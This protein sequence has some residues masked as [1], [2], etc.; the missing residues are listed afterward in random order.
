MAR[1]REPSRTPPAPVNLAVTRTIDLAPEDWAWATWRPRPAQLPAPP[2]V[3][4]LPFKLRPAANR[5]ARLLVGT[6]S[7]EWLWGTFTFRPPIA[8][9][10]AHFWLSAVTAPTEGTTPE[11]LAR[12]LEKETF[13]GHIT[14][15]AVAARVADGG[16]WWADRRLV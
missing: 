15:G 4:A 16:T 3:K 10:A 13:D 8:R 7:G 14:P 12:R 11:Q 9:E 5:L 1:P 6:G 2:A